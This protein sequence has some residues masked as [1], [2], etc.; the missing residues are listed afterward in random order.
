MRLVVPILQLAGQLLRILLYAR[1]STDEQK[2]SSIAD[3]FLACRKWLKAWGIED[4]EI[5]EL[6]DYETSGEQRSRPGIDRYV[7]ALRTGPGT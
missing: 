1:Y 5:Q 4:A 7:W 6:S 3:Q 2:R